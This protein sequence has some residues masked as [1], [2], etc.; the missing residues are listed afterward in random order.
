MI[1]CFQFALGLK[2]NAADPMWGWG[3]CKVDLSPRI[4]NR[5]G[6]ISPRVHRYDQNPVANC[7]NLLNNKHLLFFV[8]VSFSHFCTFLWVFIGINRLST[9][10]SSFKHYCWER[11]QTK[12]RGK[13]INRLLQWSR[14]DGQWSGP[15][16]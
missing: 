9:F 11:T 3:R 7:G 1:P 13:G 4:A 10:K 2:N 8:F 5:T 6:C 16:W 12:P 15:G 14:Q